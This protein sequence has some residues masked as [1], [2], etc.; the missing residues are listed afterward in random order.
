LSFS[1]GE[2]IKDAPLIESFKDIFT[3]GHVDMWHLLKMRQ[4][5]ESLVYQ[6]FVQFSYLFLIIIQFEAINIIVMLTERMQ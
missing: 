5:L 2:H 1:V 6:I 4:Y 3:C